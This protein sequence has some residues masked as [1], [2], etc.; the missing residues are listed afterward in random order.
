VE[1]GD[2]AAHAL[3]VGQDDEDGIGRVSPGGGPNALAPI[4]TPVAVD[5]RLAATLDDDVAAG[6]TER[7]LGRRLGAAEDGAAGDESRR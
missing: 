4:Q 5:G 7:D 6:P 1:V 2:A 3:A